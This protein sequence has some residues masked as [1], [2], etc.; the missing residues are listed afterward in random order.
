MSCRCWGFH[1][2]PA[3]RTRYNASNAAGRA[4]GKRGRIARRGA[5]EY[6]LVKDKRVEHYR[7]QTNTQQ[8]LLTV[9]T[10][11]AEEIAFPALGGAV[12]MRDVY[13]KWETLARQAP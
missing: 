2:R 1:R 13:A 12:H 10:A 7:R 6:V 5:R 9:Y 3:A 4:K 8:W 11:E